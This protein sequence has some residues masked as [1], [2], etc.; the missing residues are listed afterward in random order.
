MKLGI[1]QSLQKKKTGG[2]M[3]P[4][5]F[6][7]RLLALVHLVEVLVGFN[8]GVSHHICSQACP[9]RCQM[10]GGFI[11]VQFPGSFGTGFPA[12]DAAD[13]PVDSLLLIVIAARLHVMAFPAVEARSEEH[14]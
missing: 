8:Q 4:V 1:A 12:E 5:F 11:G 6:F 9:S 10:V 14:T 3:P 13:Y 7:F 2:Y